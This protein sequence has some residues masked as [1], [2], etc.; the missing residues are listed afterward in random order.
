AFATLGGVAR[1][2]NRKALATQLPDTVDTFSRDNPFSSERARRELAW[3][4][5][6]R[7]ASGIPEAF[8]WWREHRA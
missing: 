5:T 8:A 4:P 1:L 7:P 2:A 6:I 3:A